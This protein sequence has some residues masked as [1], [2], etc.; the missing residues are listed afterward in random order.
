MCGFEATAPSGYHHLLLR[1]SP[2]AGGF[3][4]VQAEDEPVWERFT[5]GGPVHRDN[6]TLSATEVRIQWYREPSRLG[7]S[8]AAVDGHDVCSALPCPLRSTRLLSPPS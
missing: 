2:I 5:V 1:P 7:T 8:L 3:L 4:R 6:P